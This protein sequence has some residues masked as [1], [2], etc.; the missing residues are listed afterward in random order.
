M[1]DDPPDTNKSIITII[2]LGLLINATIGFGSLAYCLVFRIEPN[3]ILLTAFISIET[4]LLGLV[5]GMLS[6]TSPTQVTT[7]QVPVPIPSQVHVTN[8]P[9]DPVPT[10]TEEKV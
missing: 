5:G 8:K 6:K 2:V 7:G 3:Q 4:G 9:D 10:T 1:A